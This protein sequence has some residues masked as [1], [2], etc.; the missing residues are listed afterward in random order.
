HGA[1]IE[2]LQIKLDEDDGAVV[3]EI[4]DSGPGIPRDDQPHI[5]DR[6]YRSD[7][8]SHRH[9]SGLGLYI[10]KGFVEAFGGTI[11]VLSP[12]DAGNGIRITVRLPLV[13][14]NPSIGVAE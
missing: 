12:L 4:A 8:R 10:A 7:Q 14:S 2:P 13:A 3:L 11:H 9:G 5:F 6:F 1:S